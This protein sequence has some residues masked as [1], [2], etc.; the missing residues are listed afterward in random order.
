MIF[1]LI[2]PTGI[3]CKRK[4]NLSEIKNNKASVSE[5]KKEN[6]LNDTATTYLN[7]TAYGDLS[8]PEGHPFIKPPWGTLNAINLNTGEYEWTIPVGNIPE[9]QKKGAPIT[10]DAS[11]P[12]PIV[13]AGGIV[14]IGGSQDHK[15]QAFDKAYRQIVVGNNASWYCLRYSVYL[16]KQGKTICSRFGFR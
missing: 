12:G 5:V 4:A 6:E 13:T 1:Y 16:R 7:V 8:D 3:Y 14:F 11:L 2:K 15:F 9:H 10:G